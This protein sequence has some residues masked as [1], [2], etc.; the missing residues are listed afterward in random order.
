ML[1][2]GAFA[3]GPADPPI[4]APEVAAFGNQA[5]MLP[6]RTTGEP[7][8]HQWAPLSLPGRCGT[9]ALLPP[10]SNRVRWTASLRDTWDHEFE[11]PFLQQSVSLSPVST[12]VGRQSWLSARVC[13]D[14]LGTGSAET[15][16]VFDIAATGGNIS[17][18]LYSTCPGFPLRRDGAW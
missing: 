11:S 1:R 14:G 8:R 6:H 18:G 3:H 5:L 10:A 16:R 15:R 13:G 9:W 7:A 17:V 12:F 4:H 2:G